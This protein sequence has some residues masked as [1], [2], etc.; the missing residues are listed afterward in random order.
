M[1]SARIKFC[2]RWTPRP[3]IVTIRDNRDYIRVL[4]Y[5]MMSVHHH[6]WRRSSGATV[7][8]SVRDDLDGA[9]AQ[10]GSV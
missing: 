3:V 6:A 4:L 5:Y 1:C 7:L 10:R 8:G 9:P 2:F